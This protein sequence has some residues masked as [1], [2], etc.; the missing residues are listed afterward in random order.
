M[1]QLFTLNKVSLEYG[2]LED[3]FPDVDHGIGEVFGNKVLVQ[4]RAPKT[5]TKG[6]IIITGQ[7]QESERWNE[8]VA[9]VL[10]VGPLAFRDPRTLAPWPEGAWFQPGDFI[11][12]PKHGGDKWT[13]NVERGTDAMGDRITE[14]IMFAVFDHYAPIGRVVNPLAM[15]AYL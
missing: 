14:E 13:V 5:K 9:K 6:G 3:A 10:A 4:L 7:T 12:V 1:N 2:S 11:R 8:Q 15:K